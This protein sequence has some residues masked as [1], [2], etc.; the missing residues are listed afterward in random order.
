VNEDTPQRLHGLGFWVVL[1]EFVNLYVLAP[2]ISDALGVTLRPAEGPGP[3]GE[4]VADFAGMRIWLQFPPGERYE[5]PREV[6]LVGM[7]REP[8][9]PDASWTDIGAHIAEHLRAVTRRNWHSR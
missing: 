3:E 5:V 7:A 9:A 1:D 4:H 6:Q 8:L 2:E